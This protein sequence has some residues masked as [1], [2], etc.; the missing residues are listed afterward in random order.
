MPASTPSR[1]ASPSASSPSPPSPSDAASDLIA[2]ID[3]SPT[4]WH[5]VEECKRRLDAA[6]YRELEEKDAW[7]LTSGD[8]VYVVRS[9]STIA[10][11]E[12]G[13]AAPESGGFRLVGS[14][15][16]SPNLRAKPNAVV[17][18]Y[19]Q[20]QLGVEIYGGVL[21]HT[22]LD[23]DLALAGRVVVKTGGGLE[24]RLVRFD[25]PMLRVPSLAIHL[26]RMVNTDGLLLNP[27][28]HLAPVLALDSGG[29]IDLKAMLADAARRHG[30]SFG[31]A[32]VL[33]FDLCAYDVVPG[34]RAGA[35][36]E[37]V[38]AARLDNLASCH[39]SISALVSASPAPAVSRGVF[40]FDHEEVGSQSAQGAQG[41][42]L[43][44]VLTRVTEAHGKSSKDG[45]HRALRRSFFVSADM[46]HALHPNY[47]EK[48]EPQHQPMLGG[49]PVIKSNVNQR[50]ATDAESAARFEGWC[51]EA[52]VVPQKF[53]TR[54]DLACGSTIGPITAAGL[55][56]PVVDVG[57]PMLSMHS[58]REMGGAADVPKMI[59]ALRAFYEARS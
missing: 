3:A 2:F 10:A 53:V 45:L 20:L 40:L 6:G 29:P 24:T 34:T 52:D 11:L 27:Q 12:I 1:S 5:A 26:D 41:S 28:T 38:F 57:N 14:H 13:D 56:M 18:R 25:A 21:L 23:R 31:S 59:A 37:Y 7:S 35:R 19:G 55:G 42:F 48:H 32:E 36:G 44:D 16:D 43:R 30:E 58:C 17:K 47:S 22:W 33:G 51:A 50:Y 9:G 15:T 49:G 8:R 46:A 54:T 39:A 4:P